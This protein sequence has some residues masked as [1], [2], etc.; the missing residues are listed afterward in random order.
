[1]IAKL[2]ELN[3][4]GIDEFKAFLTR[5]KTTPSDEE[6]PFHLLSCPDHTVPVEMAVGDANVETD[7]V[8]LT[9]MHLAQR[10]NAL[11]SSRAELAMIC[12][13]K[14]IGAWLSLA[15]FNSIC[16]KKDDGTWK[17]G[18][19]KRYID[20]G[21]GDEWG[22]AIHRRNIVCSALAVYHLHG[23][24]ARLCLHGPA[25]VVSD[26][27]EVIGA[28]EDVMLNETMIEVLDR[29]YWDTA[30]D[31]PKAGLRGQ[32]PYVDGSYRRFVNKTYGFYAQHYQTYDFWTMTADEIIALLP[33][34]YQHLLDD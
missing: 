27:A 15:L 25:H 11:V 7:T 17:V 1:M 26:Y 31:R 5:N 21:K 30:T 34:E 24:N 23:E 32:S 14:G 9:R 4:A 3:Q 28:I 6:P 29:L 16:A 33:E 20:D 22:F 12:E 18:Q 2:A 13:S 19:M 8:S 10:V